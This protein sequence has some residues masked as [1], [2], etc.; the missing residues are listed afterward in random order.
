MTTPQDRAYFTAAAVRGYLGAA[1]MYLA[2]VVQ[3]NPDLSMDQVLKRADVEASLV[4]AYTDA[5]AYVTEAVQEAWDA[6]GGDQ[7]SHVLKSL[8]RDVREAYADISHFRKLLRQAKSAPREVT[9]QYARALAIRNSLTVQH[10]ASASALENKIVTAGVRDL[11]KTYK[12][13][14][15]HP[16][17]P[18][19][20]FWCRRLH[21]VTIPLTADFGSYLGGPA[22]LSGT[23]RLTQPPKPYLGILQGPQL[24]PW[25]NC[26]LIIVPA[27]AAPAASQEAGS[28][29]SFL[30]ASA[31]RAMPPSKFRML[32][33]FLRAAAHELGMVLERLLKSS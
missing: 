7:R 16:E 2:A 9:E 22:A 15:A 28:R 1:G 23:G 19:C 6:G 25:C 4:Q 10:A 11:A 14:V 18:T 27:G 20:C 26:D 13:W 8:M 17:N 24:H 21:G 33:E 29:P 3:Q 5:Q 12:R 30:S 31:V 32:I